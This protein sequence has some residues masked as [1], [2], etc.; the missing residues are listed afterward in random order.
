MDV[1]EF[2]RDVNQKV[3]YF[4][5]FLFSKVKNYPNLSLGEQVSFGSIGLGLLLILTSMVLFIL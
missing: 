3:S 4:F 1:K 5:T 2:G